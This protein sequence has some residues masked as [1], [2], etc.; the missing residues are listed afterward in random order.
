MLDNIK[1]WIGRESS[2]SPWAEASKWAKKSDYAFRGT[3]E[4]DGFVVEGAFASRPWRMEYGPPQR[5]YLE[6]RELRLRM[7]L[8][9]PPLMQMVVMTKRLME[10]LE[11]ETFERYTEGMQT[12][13]DVSTPEEMRWLAMFP[14]FSVPLQRDLRQRFGAVASDTDIA[15]AWFDAALTDALE[16]AAKSF[17]AE[18]PPFVMMTLRGRVYVRLQMPELNA[19]VLP[20]SVALLDAAAHAALRA[21][22]AGRMSTEDEWPSTS[23]TAW[24]AHVPGDDIPRRR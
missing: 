5:T 19:R 14:K 23:S 17:L 13:I 3:K 24:Q 18:Q 11:R 6:G 1:R 4:A 20:Q 7:D 9:L 12:Q 10:V 21:S 8:G 15:A 22:T 2:D 16:A